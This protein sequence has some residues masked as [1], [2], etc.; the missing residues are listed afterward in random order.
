VEASLGERLRENGLKAVRER[1]SVERYARGVER[2]MAAAMADR[3]ALVKE[4]A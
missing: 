4:G 2:I 3:P 1:F